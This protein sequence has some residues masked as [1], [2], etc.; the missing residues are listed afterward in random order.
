MDP[1]TVT[2]PLSPR[3]RVKAA[4]EKKEPLQPFDWTRSICLPLSMHNCVTCHGSGMRLGRKLRL[5]PCN[6]V[7]RSIFR[8]CFDKFL[9]NLTQERSV[10]RVSL[11]P[12]SGRS[13][14][15]TWG[16]KD[17]EYI[18][19]FTLVSK[20]VL[21]AEELKLWRM[22]FVLG[23]EWKLCCRALGID[24]GNFFHAVYRVEQKLG[25]VFAELQPYALYPIG[26]YYNGA[27]RMREVYP[28]RAPI[29]PR[30]SAI[31]PAPA[32]LGEPEKIEPEP[33]YVETIE[34]QA[35][36]AFQPATSNMV[37]AAA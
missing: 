16:R 37:A 20:R 25:R 30:Y 6:C 11:E 8:L 24:R 1:I 26:D 33:G 15:S 13:R 9:R 28:T 29:E 14:P 19:D 7:L 31:A 32:P 4:E 36:P 23:A 12:H 2:P 5:Q 18:A 34:E 21:S 35:P 17:E 10:S 27:S 3:G 22:H